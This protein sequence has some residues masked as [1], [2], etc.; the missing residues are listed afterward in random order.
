MSSQVC[1]VR[2]AGY[3]PWTL[4]LGSDREHR[5]PA[6]QAPPYSRLQGA[7]PEGAG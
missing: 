5:L 4:G 6:L 7:A 1:V 2:I 3:G